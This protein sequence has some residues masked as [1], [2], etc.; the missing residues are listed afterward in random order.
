MSKV[1]EEQAREAV[2]TLINYL[3][4]DPARAELVGTPQR[5]I[6]LYRDFFTGYEMDLD[7]DLIDHPASNMIEMKDIKFISFCEHHLMPIVGKIDVAYIPNGKIIGIGKII[8]IIEMFTR[9]LQIQERF[10]EQIAHALQEIL[11]PK[12]VAVY[13]SAEHYCLR[14]KRP[15]QDNAKLCTS[16]LLGVFNSIV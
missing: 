10:T 13:V 3:G 12:G 1:S 7:Q 9:R 4:D 8:R 5:V 2:R 16:C 15:D 11:Q 6:E 14:I